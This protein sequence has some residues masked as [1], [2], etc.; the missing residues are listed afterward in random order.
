VDYDFTKPGN[1]PRSGREQ[2]G[3]IAFLPRTIDKLRAYGAGTAGEYNALR[4]LSG[5]V[6]D[7]FGV[8]PEQAVEAVRQNPTDEGV[9][10]WLNEH[11]TKH[12]TTEEIERYNEAILSAGP[13]NEEGM[14]RFRANLERLGF[15]DR[16]DVK[17]H[18]DAEDLEEGREVA[19]RG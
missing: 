9:L 10:T 5:R 11:G 8:T 1:Y 15:G 16:T 19:R 6:Y 12:P 4:G 18:I 13:Q 17:T 2:L 14:T 3:G 7:L